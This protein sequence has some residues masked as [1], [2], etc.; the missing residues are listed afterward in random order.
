MSKIAVAVAHTLTGA[1]SGAIKFLNE[2]EESRKIVPL[3]VSN[4]NKMGYE[5]KEFKIDNPNSYLYEDCYLRAKMANEWGADL[6]VEIHL[7]SS[8]DESANGTEVYIHPKDTDAIQYAKSINNSICSALGTFDRTYGQGYKTGEFIV[9]ANTKM[10]AILLEPLFCSSKSDTG[11]YT[12]EKLANAIVEG[13][14]GKK[15]EVSKFPLPLKM[16]S[17]AMTYDGEIKIFNKGDLLTADAENQFAYSIEL[18]GKRCWVEKANVKLIGLTDERYR[19]FRLQV[20]DYPCRVWA[21]EIKPFY[22]GELITARFE[23]SGY[24]A[25]DIDGVRS[26]I[27]KNATENR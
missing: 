5:A 27:R 22:D 3:V 9:L 25:L 13:I 12:P 4:L 2:S 8:D 17:D 6:Y 19:R 24:Y 7:N 26:Y 18:D 14:S 1:G 10:S 21:R 16:S 11:K 20:T 23:M 15:V